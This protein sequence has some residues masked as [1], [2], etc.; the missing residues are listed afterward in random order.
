M[1]KIGDIDIDVKPDFEPSDHFC[2]TNASTVFNDELKKHPC[3]TCRLPLKS[4][5]R[6][7]IRI[8]Q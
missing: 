5:Q 8:L 6:V 1:L 4:L 2:W 3:Q 7:G